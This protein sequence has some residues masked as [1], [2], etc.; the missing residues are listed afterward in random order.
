MNTTATVAKTTIITP[1]A[2]DA[3]RTRASLF[4]A[5]VVAKR[6]SIGCFHIARFTRVVGSLSRGC[7]VVH[8]YL[9]H[10]T[11][12]GVQPPPAG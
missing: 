5:R 9:V 3:R 11:R 10:L 1:G 8:T 4:S 2:T 12:V 7:T 6:R